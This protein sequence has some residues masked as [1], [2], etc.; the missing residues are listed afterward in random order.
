MPLESPQVEPARK[1]SWPRWP[2]DY[3]MGKAGLEPATSCL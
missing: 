2:S 3:R 1:L